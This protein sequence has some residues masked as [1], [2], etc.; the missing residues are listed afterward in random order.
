LIYARTVLLAAALSAASPLIATA[1][2]IVAIA[3]ARLSALMLMTAATAT[4]VSLTGALRIVLL[5]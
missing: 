2:S 1:A 4:T 3:L 5:L